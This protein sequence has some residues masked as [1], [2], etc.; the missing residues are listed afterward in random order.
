MQFSENEAPNNAVMWSIALTSKSL[1]SA[2]SCYSNKRRELLGTPHGI[3]IFHH[4]CFAPGSNIQERCCK[5]ITYAS[6]NTTTYIP[7]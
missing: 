1:K 4:Y 7:V 6:K 3:E 2:E 5:S